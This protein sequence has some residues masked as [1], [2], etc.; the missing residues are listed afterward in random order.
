MKTY[1]FLFFIVTADSTQTLF[2]VQTK[3]AKRLLLPYAKLEI[4]RQKF[5][6][7]VLFPAHRKETEIEKV[8]LLLT[9]H[10]L[11][12]THCSLLTTDCSLLRTYFKEQGKLLKQV[13]VAIQVVRQH[14]KLH[15]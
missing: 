1:E 15:S 4:R 9:T 11:L 12:I 6:K 7:I 10:S 2:Q 5:R 8:Y 3:P 13:E 14:N